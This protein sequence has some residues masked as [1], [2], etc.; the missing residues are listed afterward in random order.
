MRLTPCWSFAASLGLL[1]TAAA[2]GGEVESNPVD[3]APA[4]DAAV[5]GDGLLGG[6]EACDDGNTDDTDGCI[7]CAFA[8][9]GD[10][11]VRRGVEACDDTTAACVRCTTCAGVADPATG[12]CYTVVP[13]LNQRPAAEAA[14]VA[15]GGH[16]LALDGAGEWAVVAP[17]WTAPF[18]PAW[19]GLTRAVDGQNQ[20]KW[21]NGAALAGPTWNPGEPNDSGGIED[22][23]EAGGAAGGWNDLACTQTRRA[24]CEAPGWVTDPASNHAY[25]TFYGLRTHPEAIADCAAVGAHLATITSDAEQAFVA[26]LAGR[27]IWIGLFQ[28]PSEGSW[29]WS[30]GERFDFHAWGPNQPDD[31][32]ANEDCVHLQAGTGLWNDR[33]CTARLPYLCEVN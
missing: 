7:A 20:W 23:V 22:C 32:Q 6:T 15:G 11:H 25:R 18:D 30:T 24:L 13:A 10:G 9:C 12:H 1:V 33:D 4:I 19:I 26:T 28:G 27:E 16:L 21:E 5:C 31:F 14:C 3:A 29:F 17:L 2:C 8:T